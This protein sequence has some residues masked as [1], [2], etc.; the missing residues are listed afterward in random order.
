M[1][2]MIAEFIKDEITTVLFSYLPCKLD[3]SPF[4]E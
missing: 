3:V 2:H 1:I 4:N